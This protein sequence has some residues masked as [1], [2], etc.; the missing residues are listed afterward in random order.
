MAVYSAGPIITLR[1]MFSKFNTSSVGRTVPRSSVIV[2]TANI[3]R[4]VTVR[5]LRV[6]GPGTIL[7]IVKNVTG[8]VTLSRVSNFRTRGGHRVHSLS[9]PD[10]PQVQLVSRNS[11]IGCAIKNNG[12]VRVVS[13]DFT[14]RVSTIARLLEGRKGLQG[15]L[16]G[17]KRSVSYGVTS[18][19][20]HMHNCRTDRTMTSGNCS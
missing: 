20:L 17:L 4:A 7:S 6:V 16:R 18:V 8:R 5:R 11:N 15:K 13:L 14:I 10:K 1:T 9:I 2:S 3:H 19:T 12:P